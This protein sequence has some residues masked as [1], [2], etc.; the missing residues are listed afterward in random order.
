MFVLYMVVADTPV[1]SVS[2]ISMVFAF[3][4]LMTIELPPFIREFSILTS[5]SALFTNNALPVPALFT[6]VHPFTRTFAAANTA[7]D[8]VCPP[9]LFPS[10]TQFSNVRAFPPLATRIAAELPLPSV[11]VNFTFLT[12]RYAL[13]CGQSTPALL[14]SELLR[15]L[16]TVERSSEATPSIMTCTSP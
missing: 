16:K 10:N 2:T 14:L 13:C 7:I 15:P 4:V 11:F 5:A 9:V 6:N 8:A 3:S 1:I 12:V